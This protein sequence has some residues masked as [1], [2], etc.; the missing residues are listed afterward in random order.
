MKAIYLLNSNDVYIGDVF[1]CITRI[2]NISKSLA[3]KII[4]DTQKF[5]SYPLIFFENQHKISKSIKLLKFFK[6]P[7][8]IS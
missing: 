1:D 8:K 6:I 2:P 4:N 3:K 7:Y 5:G